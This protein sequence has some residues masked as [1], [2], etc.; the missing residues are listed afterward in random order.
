M[1]LPHA[2]E[3][4]KRATDPKTGI[5]IRT[6]QVYDGINDV[7]FHRCETMFGFVAPRKDWAC[8]ICG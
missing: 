3:S 8:R 4:A 1:V 2:V 7:F 5:S 6:I